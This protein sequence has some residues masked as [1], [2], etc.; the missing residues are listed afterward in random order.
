MN[1]DLVKVG[2]LVLIVLVG[3]LV[4]NPNGFQFGGALQNEGTA[5]MTEEDKM[6]QQ[7][8]NQQQQQMQMEQHMEQQKEQQKQMEMEQLGQYGQ[9]SSHPQVDSSIQ[10][11]RDAPDVSAYN[12]NVLPH[13]QMSNAYAPQ[14][15]YSQ[16]TA[17]QFTGMSCGPQD[18]LQAKDLLPREN[19]Y[20]VWDESNPPVQG[21]LEHKNYLESGYHYGINTVGQSLR[22]ANRQLRSDPPIPQ[23]P[24]G[25]W[26]NSTIS[27]DTNRRP[28]EIDSC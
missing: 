15:Q 28:F 25:P 22:N 11:Q 12:T 3:I 4:F 6:E 14:G 16:D 18:T 2:S 26:H 1:N 10:D 13:P 24:V 20:G 8:A 9:R 19:A 21:H 5:T 23:V 17:E 27:P 7:L